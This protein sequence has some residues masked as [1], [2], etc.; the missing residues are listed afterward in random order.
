MEYLN[1]YALYKGEA[2]AH[3]GRTLICN[4]W[5]MFDMHG[6][7]WQ[8]AGEFRAWLATAAGQTPEHRIL[9][10]GSHGTPS[11][12]LRSDGR[13]W[14]LPTHRSLVLGFRVALP[15]DPNLPVNVHAR[16]NESAN[17]GS[18]P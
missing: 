18:A 13:S 17:L 16:P 8:R 15:S 7:V 3:V 4:R 11:H 10:G 2:A 5:G 1:Q 6:N 14:Y 9:R 12:R